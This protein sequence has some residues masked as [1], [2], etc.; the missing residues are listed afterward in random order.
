[1]TKWH[2]LGG[3]DPKLVWLGLG[4][5]LFWLTMALVILLWNW[6][7]TRRNRQRPRLVNKGIN[8][9]LPHKVAAYEANRDLPFRSREDYTRRCMDE[10]CDY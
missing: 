8:H 5:L 7:I 6:I 9:P 3:L 10:W 4:V 2:Y 1:M